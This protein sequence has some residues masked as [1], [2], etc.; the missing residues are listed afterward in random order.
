[1]PTSTLGDIELVDD[2]GEFI[3]FGPEE[4]R[5]RV[6]F[7]DY[8]EVYAVP[9]LYEAVF[10]DQLGMCSADVVGGLFLDALEPEGRAAEAERVLDLGAGSGIGGAVLR[11]GGVGAVVGLDLEPVAAVAA[12][13]DR[14]GT[15]EEYLVGNVGEDA[16]LLEELAGKHF[17][18]VVA[19]SAIGA[20]HIPLEVLA[21][22][23]RTVLEPDGLFA[24]AV[25]E[26]L[27]P[28]FHEEFFA[29]VPATKLASKEYVHRLEPGGGEHRATAVVA[30]RS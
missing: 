4:G 26:D 14:P 22:T 10:L 15:Y 13:R 11:A 3:V 5:R 9:G 29:M 20:G 23:I 16:A 18:A 19:V 7:H 30:R 25:A 1:M 27:M 12:E 6:S 28:A 21:R 8:A 2:G 17:T 24:F